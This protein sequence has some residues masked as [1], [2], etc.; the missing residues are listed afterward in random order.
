MSTLIDRHLRIPQY[1]QLAESLRHKIVDGSLQPGDRLPSL[2]ELKDQFGANQRTAEKAYALL[3]Q[4]HLIRRE[5]GRGVFVELPVSRKVTNLVA[6]LDHKVARDYPYHRE[7]QRGVRQQAGVH[8]KSITMMDDPATFNHWDS[9][10]GVVLEDPGLYPIEELARLMPTGFPAVRLFYE[11]PTIS[12]VVADDVAGVAMAVDHLIDLGHRRIGYLGG[13]IEGQPLLEIRHK[14]YLETLQSH[15]IASSAQWTFSYLKYTELDF[16]EYGYKAM[17]LW[18]QQGWRDLGLTA[19]LA[20]ND[21][22]AIGMIRALEE[23]RIHVPGDVSIVGY[24]GVNLS[25]YARLRLTTVE[26]PLFEMGATAIKVLLEQIENPSREREVIKLPVH[27]LNGES[28][29]EPK[30]S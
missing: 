9:M 17:Q 10:D 19:M 6:F 27:F 12:C 20:Q 1:L 5:P 22:T 23:N 2:N 13:I 16:R 18:L 24:D 21:Y 15:E 25:D 28:T 26:V 3:E 29:A 4:D 30:K 11:E 8:G 7:I 14:A